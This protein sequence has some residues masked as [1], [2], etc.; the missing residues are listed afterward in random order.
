MFHVKHRSMADHSMTNDVSRETS[1][2][3]ELVAAP[4]ARWNRTVDLVA[5][6]DEALACHCR[7]RAQATRRSRQQLRCFT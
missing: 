5:I 3:L 6:G 4:L 1:A 2:A 7:A